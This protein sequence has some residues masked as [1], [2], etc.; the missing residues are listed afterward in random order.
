MTYVNFHALGMSSENRY[1]LSPDPPT[2][3][4]A[5]FLHLFSSETGDKQ[6]Y[7]PYV[8]PF[9]SC[10]PSAGGIEE[11]NPTTFIEK[12]VRQP[13]RF[14][15]SCSPPPPS[16]PRRC[17]FAD[18]VVVAFEI[19]ERSD[20]EL[21]PVPQREHQVPTPAGTRVRRFTDSEKLG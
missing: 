9:S 11:Q 3:R 17:A 5:L 13:L 8:A 15:F 16:S 21:G 7:T 1:N 4:R 18:V 6:K 14:A 20:L 12:F 10:S 2:R 19:R